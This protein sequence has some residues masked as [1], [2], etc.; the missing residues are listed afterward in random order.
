[1][2][3]SS[4]QKNRLAPWALSDALVEPLCVLGDAPFQIR[5]RHA[6]SHS[7]FQSSIYP[8]LNW[9]GEGGREGRRRCFE[10]DSRHDVAERFLSRF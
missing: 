2:R 7:R 10:A 6:P 8:I 4:R 1:M 9:G 3:L 5:R